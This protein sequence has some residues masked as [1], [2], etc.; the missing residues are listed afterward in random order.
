MKP[1]ASK[2]IILFIGLILLKINLEIYKAALNRM[3]IERIKLT[4]YLF[5]TKT[6]M[7]KII[8]LISGHQFELRRSYP[9][10]LRKIKH[11][12]NG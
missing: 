9:L 4:K 10:L 11:L 2:K 3:E 8:N 5:L 7:N 6:K 1:P 12:S